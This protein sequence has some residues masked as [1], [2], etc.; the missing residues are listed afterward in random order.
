MT[1]GLSVQVCTNRMPAFTAPPA[2]IT[3]VP[4]TT[5]VLL[6]QSAASTQAPLPAI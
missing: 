5:L 6:C 2:T 1:I 4:Q 3:M